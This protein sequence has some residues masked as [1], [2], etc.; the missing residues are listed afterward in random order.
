MH[1]REH[2]TAAHSKMRA[3]RVRYNLLSTTRRVSPLARSRG[4]GTALVQGAL[5]IWE[6]SSAH[7]TE[8]VVSFCPI[9]KR[10]TFTAPAD[11]LRRHGV[12]VGGPAEGCL[13]Q[14]YSWET[15]GDF[16]RSHSEGMGGGRGSFLIQTGP[17][18]FPLPWARPG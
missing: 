6:Q 14:V 3:R 15:G 11:P 10:G 4:A 16:L 8:C 17:R 5:P 13:S 2:F 7:S 9:T 18:L 1:C 12:G